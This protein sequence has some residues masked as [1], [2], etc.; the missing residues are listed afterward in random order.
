MLLKVIRQKLKKYLL[1]EIKKLKIKNLLEAIAS[2][3]HKFWKLISN[4]VYLNR[5]TIDLDKRLLENYYRN[6]GYYKV[7]IIEFLC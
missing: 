7:K 5:G 6:L 4:K 1:L 2:E 3:E